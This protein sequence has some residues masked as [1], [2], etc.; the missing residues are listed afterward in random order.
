VALDTSAITPTVRALVTTGF[1]GGYTTFSTF[2]YD[3]ATLLEDGAYLR[4][5]VYVLSSVLLSLVGTFIG[6]SAARWVLRS[7]R[8]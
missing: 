5:T 3:T 7:V 2:S 6:V 4:A 8:S 1:C